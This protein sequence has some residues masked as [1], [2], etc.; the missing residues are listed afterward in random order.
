MKTT[1][2]GRGVRATH[3]ALAAALAGALA[4]P[5]PAAAA[6]KVLWPLSFRPVFEDG[7][8]TTAQF[9]SFLTSHNA[10]GQFYVTKLKLPPGS[11]I[12]GLVAYYKGTNASAGG[13]VELYRTK[14]GEAPEV[15]G[16]AHFE[17]LDNTGQ[18]VEVAAE[19]FRPRVRR[20]YLHSLRVSVYNSYS[21][22]YGVKVFYRQPGD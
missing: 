14:M 20:G 12:T 21:F 15:M 9:A 22:V 19:V 17:S 5:M 11:T 4:L 2:S 1:A 13:G 8:H 16:S 10:N 6:V 3:L 18:I 7:Y